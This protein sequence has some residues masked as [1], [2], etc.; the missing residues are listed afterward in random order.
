MSQDNVLTE[1]VQVGLLPLLDAV[2]GAKQHQQY[3][4]QARL[5]VKL[6]PARHWSNRTPW[7]KNETLW[8]AF[9]LQAGGRR[10]VYFGGGSGSGAHFRDAGQL[11][12]DLDVTLIEAGVYA[13][14]WVMA[15]NH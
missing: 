15:P 11:F 7:D 1:V 9:V 6:L 3:R 10:Q 8:G 2:N 12:P 5:R 4:T 14:R 13:P